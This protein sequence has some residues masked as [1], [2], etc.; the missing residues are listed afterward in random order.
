MVDYD[1][2]VVWQGSESVIH[3]RNSPTLRH[4]LFLAALQLFR[5]L[6]E[7]S[8]PVEYRARQPC[9]M[10]AAGICVG[11]HTDASLNSAFLFG[12]DS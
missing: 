4:R 8:A 7:G 11:G 12:T 10:P 1:E 2:M 3:Y 9:P 5:S 6:F